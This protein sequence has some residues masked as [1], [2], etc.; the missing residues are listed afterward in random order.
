MLEEV[1]LGLSLEG[2][3]LSM[4]LFMGLWE[5]MEDLEGELVEGVW[6]ALSLV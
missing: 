5:V 2:H 1:W 6:L 4:S 3:E